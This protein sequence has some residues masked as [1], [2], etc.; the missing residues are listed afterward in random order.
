VADYW[1]KDLPVSRGLY[2]FDTIHYDVYR[3]ETVAVE[4]IKSG[5][6]D[7][8]EEYIARNWATAFN[9]PAV[10]S[11]ELVKVKIPNKI[12]SGMQAFLFN[13]RKSKFTDARVREAIGL[14]MDYEW[15]NDTLFYGAYTRSQSFFQNTDFM[16]TGTPQPDEI[17]LLEPFR[18]QLPP[19]LFTEP[20]T[21]PTTDASGSAR[22]NL[23]KAQAL[24]ND[25]GWIMKDGQRVNRETGEVLD[26]EFMMSQRTFEKVI[27]GMIRNLKRL[28]IR[29][30]FRYV[31]DS[32]YQK[33]IDDRDFEIIS[34]WW[35]QGLFFPGNEQIGY[36]HSSQA[37]VAGG[38]N[39]SGMKSPAVDALLDRI[40]RAS[41]LDELRPAARAL[42]RVLLWNHVVIPHWHLGAWRLLY[43]NKFGRPDIAPYYGIGMESWWSTE[44]E[45]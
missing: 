32:Q 10:E 11:G 2:N 6:Y 28:G 21:N 35:N 33:R 40:T 12:P 4:A 18:A 26:V 5:R 41:T 24:L 43:W 1:A 25:A 22:D 44:A 27:G 13:I 45:K 8:R 39:Y 23:L 29:G 9:I 20:Y 34:I 19:A 36:W 37:D 14:A 17:A 15:M 38:N 30:T 16:A 31:D 42:D 3:D 7:L